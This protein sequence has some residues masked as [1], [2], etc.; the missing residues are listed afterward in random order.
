MSNPATLSSLERAA[1]LRSLEA[2]R[3][4]LVVIG[5]G[6][7]G[8]G[9]ARLAS[10]RGLRVAL[11][12]ANDF[13]AGTSSRSTKL[14]HGGLRYLA[15]GD[16]RLVREGA[17]ERKR[18]ARLAPHLAEPL[19]MVI[20]ARSRL[21]AWRYRAG[22]ALYERLGAVAHADRHRV[23]SAGDLAREEPALDRALFPRACVYREYLTE[24]ARLVLANLRAAAACGAVA[25]NH[26][27]AGGLVIEDGRAAGIEA[28]CRTS[29]ARLR[30]RARSVVNAAGPWAESVRR[31]EDP[32]A[33]S[34]LHLSKGIHI[35]VSASRLAVRHMLFLPASDGRRVF[36]IPRGDVVYLG[37]TDTSH[38]QPPVEWPAIEAG[39]VEY[40]LEVARRCLGARDLVAPDV[41]G[42]WAGLRPLVRE[43]GRSPSE[44]SRRDEVWIGPR[45][46]VTVAGGK[47]T[48]YRPMAQRVLERACA[49]SGLRPAPVADEPPLPGGDLAGDLDTNACRIAREWALDPRV[50]SRLVRLYGAESVRV[51]ALG[52]EPLAAGAPVLVG[53]ID[54]AVEVEG[55]LGLEDALY[56]RTRAAVYEPAW[57]E[58]L[59]AP[60]AARM[61][62]R[63]GW[64]EVRVEREIAAV[65]KRF[66]SEL[67]FR[68]ESPS[69]PPS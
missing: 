12:E 31:L 52:P 4:D 43:P 63:L 54:W 17:L 68:S 34:L 6:I 8:A 69:P 15:M 29:G 51:L 28:R 64:D 48:G 61:A 24:D 35:V 60:A 20:P 14:V 7:T 62:A 13:A 26:V 21:E 27:E 5:G 16:F 39:D 42:S 40:L 36:A 37:T 41:L 11:V 3:F 33:P 53:E 32:G 59:L 2:E 55:A 65:S 1:R 47:L 56:R 66:A 18:I 45:G 50:A 30:I 19:W 58:K 25:V 38:P 49:E 46:V 44:I 10:L 23:W 67:P 57:R 22:V 9:V